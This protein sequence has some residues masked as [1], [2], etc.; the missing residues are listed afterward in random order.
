MGTY[1]NIAQPGSRRRRT[2]FRRQFVWHFLGIL[3]TTFLLTCVLELVGLFLIAL[4]VRKGSIFDHNLSMQILVV[5]LLILLP[6]VVLIIAVIFFSWLLGRKISQPVAELRLAVEKIRQQDLNFSISYQGKN[7]LGDLCLAFNELRRE[8]Q[9]SLEREWRKQEETR[10][11]IA[12]LSH[13]L[14][15]PVTI[16]QGHVEGLARTEA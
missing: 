11:M 8:L 10:T 6:F 14:R 12:A 3:G 9:G 2:S 13:D 4:N 5:F 16:I 15:T 7:E 1:I